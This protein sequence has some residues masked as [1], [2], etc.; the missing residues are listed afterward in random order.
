MTPPLFIKS[1]AALRADVEYPAVLFP[2][3]PNTIASNEQ[4]VFLLGNK[5]PQKKRVF[6]G[7]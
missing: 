5:K 4:S 2:L 3:P 6:W 7:F 1:N